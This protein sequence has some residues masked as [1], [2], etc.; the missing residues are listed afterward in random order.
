MDTTPKRRE[1]FSDIEKN[2]LLKFAREMYK[3]N[4]KIW[5]NRF[6][7]D[8]VQLEEVCLNSIYIYFLY[9]SG[10]EPA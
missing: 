9:L 1:N 8:L 2:E 4:N 3:S 5:G 6:W 7:Q 10:I